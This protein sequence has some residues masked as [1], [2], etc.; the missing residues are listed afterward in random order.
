VNTDT[1]LHYVLYLPFAIAAIGATS[2]FWVPAL[3]IRAIFNRLRSIKRRP[4]PPECGAIHRYG[5][6]PGVTCDK[7]LGHEGSHEYR[8]WAFEAGAW[9]CLG[10]RIEPRS[11]RP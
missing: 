3:T 1:I 11:P 6:G 2:I 10:V 5:L 4:P 9:S 7:P 8:G